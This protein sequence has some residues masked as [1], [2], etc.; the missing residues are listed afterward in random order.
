MPIVQKSCQNCHRPGSIA[1]FSLLSYEEARPW[2]KAIREDVLK[3]QMPP[4][5]VDR[6]IGISHFKNDIGLT[7]Q[8]IQ[9][10][11]KWVDGGAAKGN[12]AD[13]PAPRKFEENDRWHIGTPDLVVSLPKDEVLAARAPDTWKD[14]VVDPHI[15]EDRWLMGVETKPT[16]GYRVVHHAATFIIHDDAEEQFTDGGQGAFLNEY[17]VG[18]N[19]DVFPE[20][21]G[22]L[23]RAG[24]KINFNLHLHADGEDTPLNMS[25]AL[26][27]YPRG[28][29]PKHSVQTENVGYV[30]DLDL[31]ANT[32]NIRSDRYFT[33]LKPTRVLSLQPHM[34][35]RGKGMCLEAIY[36][37]GGVYS[38]KVETLNCVTN[39][40]FGWHI[41]YLY[42]EDEQPLLPAGTVLHVMS[43]HDNTAK[44]KSAPDADNWIGF[45]QRS[46]DDMSFCWVSYFSMD[47]K[48]FKDAVLDRR[49]KQKA[50]STSSS[51]GDPLQQ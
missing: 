17:A 15:T 34:H 26:K 8:E 31:P 47:D 12:D 44:N 42:P 39:Y 2:A 32:D 7:D 50:V 20:G 48:E 10:I 45:G 27:F 6:N 40:R 14:I 23:I 25:L 11:A 24:S 3:K 16:K 41:V 46:T 43:W 19:G 28:Y 49:Q 22:R 38:D 1:P 4:F 33:L 29:V 36:P 9:T 35:L 21:S 5:Y 18:K 37:G 51:A 13:M 30:T